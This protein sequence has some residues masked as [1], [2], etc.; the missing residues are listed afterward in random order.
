MFHLIVKDENLKRK[1]NLKKLRT[2][3]EAFKRAGLEYTVHRTV[4]KSDPVNIAASVTGGAGNAVIVMGGDGTL[5][6][7]L[8]GFKNFNDNSL[9]LIPFGTGN[10]FAKSAK[11]PL[12]V[13]KAVN[14]IIKGKPAPVDFIQFSSGLRSL[15]AAGMGIDVDVL[16]RVYTKGLRGKTKYL[17][18]LLY[19][20]SRFKSYDFTAVL[21]DGEE[22]THSGLIAAVGNGKYIGGGIKVCPDAKIDDGYLDVMIAD[23]ISKSAIPSAFLKLM[24]GKVNKVGQVT[25]LKVKSVK[26]IPHG[27]YTVQADG[28]LY[29]NTAIEARVSDDPQL[30]YKLK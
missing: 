24:R 18:A 8:N 10:D 27:Q 6:D 15:N 4:E 9:G 26:F 12:N 25:T 3:E 19:C 13:K 20:L 28:E 29:D 1:K 17:R 11:I 22:I 21:D 16:K 2:V 30:F 7:V 14:I 5:H 23:Y